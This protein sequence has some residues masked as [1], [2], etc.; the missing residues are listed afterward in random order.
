MTTQKQSHGLIHEQE[1]EPSQDVKRGGSR[2]VVLGK[3]NL[4]LALLALP[5]LAVAYWVG[6]LSVFLPDALA[7][8]VLTVSLVTGWRRGRVTPGGEGSSTGSFCGAR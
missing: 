7:L 1:E 4:P 3:V 5:V 2:P 6:V 8:L